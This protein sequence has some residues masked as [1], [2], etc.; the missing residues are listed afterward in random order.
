MLLSAARFAAGGC[1]QI[2]TVLPTPLE[3][4]PGIVTEVRRKDEEQQKTQTPV[5]ET[6]TPTPP[7]ER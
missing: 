4:V 5:K 2:G 7:T 6:V 3:D 1:E